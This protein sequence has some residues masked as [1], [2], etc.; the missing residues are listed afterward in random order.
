MVWFWC[1]FFIF[2]FFYLI[3]GFFE[4]HRLPHLGFGGGKDAL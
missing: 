1:F 3:D 2:I 4:D